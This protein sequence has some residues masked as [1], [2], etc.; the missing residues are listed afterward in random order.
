MAAA[1]TEAAS[2]AATSMAVA[3]MA[4]TSMGGTAVTGLCL[5]APAGIRDGTTDTADIGEEAA[6]MG[7]AAPITTDMAAAATGIAS[8]QGT[9]L[10][11][12]ASTLII[13][14]TKIPWQ[15]DLEGPRKRPFFFSSMVLPIPRR[16]ENR[17]A[18]PLLSM[19]SRYNCW[20]DFD[21]KVP[22]ILSAPRRPQT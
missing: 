16:C 3:S 2:T 1:F 22:N 14:A 8:Q 13:I 12:A 19:E 5:S 11:I 10:P 18:S 17:V 7:G 15:Y 4:A 9:R 21:T 20:L 6:G